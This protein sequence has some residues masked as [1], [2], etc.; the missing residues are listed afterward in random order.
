MTK[1]REKKIKSLAK[2][3]GT[4]L[5]ATSSI[6]TAAMRHTNKAVAEA[7]EEA[8]F[9]KKKAKVKRRVRKQRRRKTKKRKRRRK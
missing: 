7:L 3:V 8:T 2:K 1:R 9:G 4:F 6:A 5:V